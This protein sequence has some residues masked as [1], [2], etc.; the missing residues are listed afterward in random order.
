MIDGAASPQLLAMGG[1]RWAKIKGPHV[2][3]W[4]PSGGSG[5]GCRDDGSVAKGTGYGDAEG[6]HIHAGVGLS[7]DGWRRRYYSSKQRTSLRSRVS[8]AD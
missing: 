6:P 3:A 2:C 8:A 1:G 5:S 4:G 7:D